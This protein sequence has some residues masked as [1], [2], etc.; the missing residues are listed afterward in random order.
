[1]M[2]D[3]I[4]NDKNIKLF[5]SKKGDGVPGPGKYI[6]IIKNSTFYKDT[7]PYPEFK[8]FFLSNNE[9]FV[10]QKTMNFQDQQ[11]ILRIIFITNYLFQR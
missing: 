6:D 4:D 3:S 11:L 5:T 1:M 7:I 2:K 9:R 10:G 8:Q